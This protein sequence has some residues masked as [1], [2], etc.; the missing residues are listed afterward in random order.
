[1]KLSLLS[2]DCYQLFKMLQKGSG[3]I[4][5]SSSDLNELRRS[6]AESCDSSHLLVVE[7]SCNHA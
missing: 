1:M 6:L 3:M 4:R 5:R 7:T 2:I